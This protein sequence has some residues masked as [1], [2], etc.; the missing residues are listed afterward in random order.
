MGYRLYCYYR[1]D[2][3]RFA[4]AFAFAIITF[5]HDSLTVDRCRSQDTKRYI[6][7]MN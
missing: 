2:G 1:F 6:N 5:Q 7:S 3:L 4:F